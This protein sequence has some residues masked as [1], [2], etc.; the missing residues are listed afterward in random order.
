M[1]LRPDRTVAALGELAIRQRCTIDP[2]CTSSAV[3]SSGIV[4]ILLR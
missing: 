4:A 1:A 2:R 3:V